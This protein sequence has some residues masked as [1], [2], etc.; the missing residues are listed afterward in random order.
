M[1][2]KQYELFEWI[3]NISVAYSQFNIQNIDSNELLN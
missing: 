1:L 2:F 3:F